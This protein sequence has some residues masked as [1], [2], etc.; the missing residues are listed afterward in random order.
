MRGREKERKRERE[1]MHGGNRGIFRDSAMRK[2]REG[3]GE[4]REGEE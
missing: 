2:V 1:K 3:E 4:E